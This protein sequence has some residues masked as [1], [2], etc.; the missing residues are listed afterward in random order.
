ME[1]MGNVKTH[2]CGCSDFPVTPQRRDEHDS[3][4]GFCAP[5]DD[6][7]QVCARFPQFTQHMREAAG[8]VFDGR[9]PHIHTFHVFHERI[10]SRSPSSQLLRAKC[11]L[12]VI[13]THTPSA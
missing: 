4:A 5:R 10:H 6:E 3:F 7:L 13:P 2:L 8:F 12:A 1:G 11:N 9:R